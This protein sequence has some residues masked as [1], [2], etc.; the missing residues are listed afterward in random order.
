MQHLDALAQG[1]IENSRFAGP[2]GIAGNQNTHWLAYTEEQK[3]VIRQ[4]YYTMVALYDRQ[5]GQLMELFKQYGV[6]EVTLFLITTDHGDLLFDHGIGEKGPMA[7]EEVL[8]VPLLMVSP[9]L[10]SPQ[11][12]DAPVS[13]ADLMPTVLEY[14]GLSAADCDGLSLR[15]LLEGKH[16]QRKG[17]CAEFMEEPDRIQYRCYVTAEWKLAEYPGEEFGELYHLATDPH[18]S[19][20]L[21]SLPEYQEIRRKLEE[22]LPLEPVLPLA[23]RPC[24]C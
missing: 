2:F 4:Y 12:V 1:E 14:A 6:Y 9:G 19:R 23:E 17:V 21:Y 18:E 16:W 5:I 24:R 11:V 10:I 22:C 7:W 3:Q 20:N 15:P 13:L 8:H